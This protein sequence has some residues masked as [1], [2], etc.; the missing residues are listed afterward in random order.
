MLGGQTLQVRAPGCCCWGGVACFN[1]VPAPAAGLDVLQALCSGWLMH[2]AVVVLSW[3]LQ[4]AG[5]AA[6]AAAAVY[7]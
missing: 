6:A 1:S 4:I 2:C 3:V 7:Y 5:A